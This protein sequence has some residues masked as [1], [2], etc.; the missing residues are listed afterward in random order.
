MSAA[1]LA[2][3]PV[4]VTG[5]STRAD[6]VVVGVNVFVLLAALVL[7][8]SVVAPQLERGLETPPLK[9]GLMIIPAGYVLAAFFIH[10]VRRVFVARP[11]NERRL[12]RNVR[13]LL[14]REAFHGRDIDCSALADELGGFPARI[15]A[16][17]IQRMAE[18]MAIE[19][20]ACIE[21][22]E[23]GRI[24]FQWDRLKESLA[25]VE[26]RRTHPGITSGGCLL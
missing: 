4:D 23:D 10:L 13:R 21:P 11:E 2:E 18:D 14:L 26:T 20:E 8:P 5:N 24:H 6:L 25:A 7:V 9:W 17:Q 22:G 15:D 1:L 3:L 19:F 16:N 12:Q